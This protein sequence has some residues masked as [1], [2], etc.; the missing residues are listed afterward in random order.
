SRSIQPRQPPD[1]D[2]CTEVVNPAW[3]TDAMASLANAA[4][5]RTGHWDRTHASESQGKSFRAGWVLRH[6]WGDEHVR[7][8]RRPSPR[9]RALLS[10]LRR[11]CGGEAGPTR[12]EAR[13][14]RVRRPRR[15]D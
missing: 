8:L 7:F 13:H 1:A 4:M 10:S 14:D 15:L 5:K 9:R 11:A 3:M 6:N 2:A 12:T